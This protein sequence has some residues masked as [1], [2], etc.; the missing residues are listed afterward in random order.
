M[1]KRLQ[2]C[3]TIL[4]IFICL[5]ACGGGSDNHSL[6]GQNL[7]PIGNPAAPSLPDSLMPQ[8]PDE[9]FER[10]HPA[11]VSATENTQLGSQAIQMQAT[12][13]Q[14]NGTALDLLGD[15]GPTALWGM[16]RWT[17][18]QGGLPIRVLLDF[19]I[20]AG[21]E[22][23]V[24]RTNYGT[25]RWDIVG[26]LP[27]TFAND[28]RT[29]YPVGDFVSPGGSSYVAVLVTA[30]TDMTINTISLLADD[31][32]TPPAAPENLVAT[33]NDPGSVA[34]DWDDVS[35]PTLD[36]YNVYASTDG[37]FEIG[38][39][40]AELLNLFPVGSSD[41]IAGGLVPNTTYY[42]GVSS[43]D[44]VGNISPLSN[45]A[46]ATTSNDDPPGMPTGLTVNIIGS[47]TV[48]LSWTAPGDGDVQG[49][50][51][52]IGSTPDFDLADGTKQDGAL[53]PGT[54]GTRSGLTPS[55]E[56]Y[57]R[58]TAVDI[59]NLESQPSNSV[60]FTTVDDAPPIPDFLVSPGYVEKGKI[61]FFNPSPTFDPDTDSSELT[62]EWDFDN[63]DV[64]DETTLGP[65]TVQWTFDTVGPAPVRLTV[66]DALS[67]IDRNE[68]L[69]V[70]RQFERFNLGNGKGNAG[71]ILSLA[72]CPENSIVGIPYRDD[73]NDI[74]LRYYNGS[75]WSVVP[76][77]A[78]GFA[79]FAVSPQG[80]VALYLDVTTTSVT[81][82]VQRYTGSWN[83]IR[84]QT[85]SGLSEP[86][87]SSSQLAVAPN[88]RI[89]VGV[90]YFNK[91][92]AGSPIFQ[93]HVWHEMADT[94]LLNIDIFGGT[95]PSGQFTATD[96]TRTNDTS[97]LLDN[98]SG[99]VNVDLITITDS[100]STTSSGI[101]TINGVPSRMFIDT[102]PDNPA[103]VFWG[104]LNSTD[105]I[106]YGDNYGTANGGSQ[107]VNAGSAAEE[108]AAIGFAG[109]NEAEVFWLDEYST[110]Q[111]ELRGYTTISDSVFS[112]G[113][114]IGFGDNAFG[115]Y[116]D[117]GSGSG[118]WIVVRESRDGQVVARYI[119]N[120]TVADALLVHNP[121][122][123]STIFTKSVPLAFP[124]DSL[125]SLH[126]QV[127]PSALAGQIPANHSTSSVQYVGEDSSLSPQIGCLTGVANE[128][129]AG[130][131]N[132]DG[133][134]VLNTGFKGIVPV[135]QSLVVE[136][137]GMAALE[138]S[139]VSD[140]AVLVHTNSGNTQISY[141][142]YSA[143]SWTGP[144]VLANPAGSVMRID[145]S[146]R[147]DGEFGLVFAT[148]ADSLQ[149]V[150]TSGASWGSPV[151]IDTSPLVLITSFIGL[152]YDSNDEA[153]VAV[154]R[155]TGG[156]FIGTI[157]D[158]GS[159][160]WEAVDDLS[161]AQ[162]FSLGVGHDSADN[163]V[164]IYLRSTASF[165]NAEVFL[166]E[167]LGGIWVPAQ[168]PSVVKML[169]IPLGITQD[170]N[171]NFIIGGADKSSSPKAICVI[172][173][174]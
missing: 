147:S 94:N 91:P 77:P 45:I 100:G 23:Y 86:S 25:G 163:P 143:G 139:P 82:S 90:I 75:A 11:G 29:S 50:N 14:I 140:R 34:L 153:A 134:L 161:G 124:D 43:V 105:R 30:G 162:C 152:D 40:G 145:T 55:V 44:M 47:E 17:N 148:D 93:Y 76:M 132:A 24:L 72:T 129:L 2:A 146:H 26:P 127:Y 167:K 7:Q 110:G 123:P 174:D 96:L 166:T 22:F 98:V 103:Q 173:Y 107:F 15:S 130:G 80:P 113:S 81:W 4:L 109:D 95:R 101:Q 165:A 38:D 71:S 19:D 12:G 122:V 8:F 128:Y 27:E 85:I 35:D 160:S 6:D 42:F 31:D 117:T 111:Q 10:E 32:L 73:N 108:L 102:D 135:T 138:Y 58:V 51:I 116:H 65:S 131:I 120:E 18:F 5:S 164:L 1:L 68:I 156:L 56:Y 57:A 52:Y 66:S 97:Y 79:D 9:Q 46:E 168:A 84:S 20:E 118:V 172:F 74:I 133:V 112:V 126:L 60:N 67:S 149:F 104:M 155:V 150:E 115:G 106:Y 88:G 151:E 39:P 49:Y 159:V 87:T 89:S 142:I 61:T 63:D 83:T 21:G 125:L 137:V 141:Y 37:P 157:P 69:M 3:L 59:F 169:G 53:Y 33:T 144:T 13:A 16:W 114:G 54:S 171:R 64:I 119:E 78:Q 154:N 158:G 92:A 121:T 70:N 99:N 62:F 28:S 36:G 136:N 48:D 41:Y 170:S